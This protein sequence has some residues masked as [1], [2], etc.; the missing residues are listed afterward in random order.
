MRNAS[1]LLLTLAIVAACS[2]DAATTADQPELL[3]AAA[4]PPAPPAASLSVQDKLLVGGTS[5][6][7]EVYGADPGVLVYLM[8]TSSAS[9]PGPTCFTNPRVCVNLNGPANKVRIAGSG[10]A[11]AN[12]TA[13]ITFF[14]PA[15]PS[16]NLRFE[17]VSNPTGAYEVSGIYTPRWDRPLNDYDGDGL[18]NITEVRNGTDPELADTDGGGANDGVEVQL[19]TNPLDPSDDPVDADGDGYVNGFDDC[20]DNNPAVN[21]GATEVCNSIDDNCDGEIDRD[22]WWDTGWPYRV[23][24]ELAAPEWITGSP[25]MAVDVDFAAA[26][27]AMGDASDLDPTS[28]RVVYQECGFGL[29]ELPSE[30]MDDIS[31]VFDKVDIADP[32]G[33]QFGAVAF[34]IDRN[35]NYNTLENFL[36][37]TTA[38]VD[39]YFGSTANPAA[40]G[41]PS[42]ASNLNVSN[43]GTVAVLENALTRTVLRR[44]DAQN[45]PQGGLTEFLGR[46]GGQNVGR[47]ASTGLGN[48][49]YFN[50]PGGGPN[51]AWLTARGDANATMTI[52]HDGPIFAAIQSTGSRAF[53]APSPVVGGFDYAYTYSMFTGRPE[54]YVKTEF[55]INT[56]NSNVGPQGAAWTA[57][58]RPFIVDNNT[59]STQYTSEGSREVPDYSW[60]RG[61]YD[62]AGSP[63]GFA[64]A[65]RQ[66]PLQRGSP[67]YATNGRWIGLVGQDYETNPATTE[68]TLNAGD[69]VVDNAITVAYPHNGLFGSISVDFYGVQDGVGVTYR[70]PEAL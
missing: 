36:A 46:Q 42:Y 48:G 21:P 62:T 19:G 5:Q 3:P 43:D 33:D 67:V 44:V 31:G 26:L 30:F 50:T 57:A 41:A 16:G 60:V 40:G 45:N 4:L 15:Q 64:A 23:P 37:N 27:A 49:I 68:R 35:G 32:I 6:T 12:G 66:S 8:G 51:G 1:H 65:F 58:V 56:D 59:F 24:L 7:L 52:L 69:V 53:Q 14:L 38:R 11:D 70:A 22:A 29:P 34:Q 55:V 25:P 13:R 47:Q 54:V 17:A 9:P 39:I 18:N 28:V 20:D 63:F 61:T 10:T 2:D